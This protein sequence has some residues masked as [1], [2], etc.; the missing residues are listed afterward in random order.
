MTSGRCRYPYALSG[1]MNI[2][3]GS[4][5]KVFYHTVYLI[6]ADIGTLTSRFWTDAE[7]LIEITHPCRCMHP[8]MSGQMQVA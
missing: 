3:A 8:D 2:R 7:S 4:L 6:R 5:T 1:Q